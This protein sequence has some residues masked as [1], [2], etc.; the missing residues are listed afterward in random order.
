MP[1]P[2]KKKKYTRTKTNLTYNI[3]QNPGVENNQTV[4][5]SG[6]FN[7]NLKKYVNVT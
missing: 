1:P 6:E 4:D 7:D 3:T 2:P 5:V